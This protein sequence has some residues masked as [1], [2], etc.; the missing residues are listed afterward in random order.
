MKALILLMI[1]MAAIAC[2][3]VQQIPVKTEI[4]VRERVVN[5]PVPGDSALMRLL[6]ECDSNRRAIIKGYSESKTSGVATSLKQNNNTFEIGFK[7]PES[8]VGVICKDSIVKQDVPVV[9][10]QVKII[11]QLK[12]YQLFLMFSGVLAWGFLILNIFIY[13]R[14]K[15]RG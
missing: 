9:V 5:V 10:P 8:E 3:P 1:I 15:I 11:N 2:K 12:N 6:I 13:A 7:K 14:K 4:Q